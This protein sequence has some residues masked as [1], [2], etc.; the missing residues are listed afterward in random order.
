LQ[1]STELTIRFHL[2]SSIVLAA[3]IGAPVIFADDDSDV[4]GI[5]FTEKILGSGSSLG[6]V[7]KFDTAVGYQFNR[8]L[9][10]EGGIPVYMVNPSN[11]LSSVTGTHS[12]SGLGDVY[13]DVRLTLANP[14]VNYTGIVT[15]G[16]P[17]GDR[18]IGF[19]TGHASWDWS[20]LFD[21]T[22]DRITP[23]AE[24][25]MGNTILDQPYFIRPFTTFGFVSHLEGGASYKLWR[26]VSV[27]A[28][29]Y[30]IE[31]AGQQTVVSKLFG[32]SSNPG[33]GAGRRHHGTF[34]TASETVGSADIARDHGLAA[35]FGVRPSRYAQFE[36]GYSHSLDY[37]LDNVFFG[38]IFNLGSL[39]PKHF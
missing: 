28:S 18:S 20:N 24:V 19:S 21:R 17:T 16:A 6:F 2:F 36:I 4:H 22:F 38:V 27:G 35:W 25:G 37:S 1:Y 30:A 8:Y 39:I 7:T 10:V 32:S 12:Q 14:V 26:M 13:A 5:T 31:P 9:A 23:F 33:S 29:L 3:A 34:D 15:A 11:S